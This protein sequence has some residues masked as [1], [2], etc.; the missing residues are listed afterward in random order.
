MKY[1][2]PLKRVYGTAL[3]EQRGDR[4]L[5]CLLSGAGSCPTG[6]KEALRFAPEPLPFVD[7]R[8]AASPK[9]GTSTARS[10]SASG[11]TRKW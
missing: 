7:E 4:Q 10:P 11:T 8:H 3:I 5:V 9:I 6:D 1:P 2:V